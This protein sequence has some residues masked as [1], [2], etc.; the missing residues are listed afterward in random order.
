MPVLTRR[1]LFVSFLLVVLGGCSKT[2]PTTSKNAT[3]KNTGL[4]EQAAQGSKPDST[5]AGRNSADPA[6]NGD[7]KPVTE[8]TTSRP[9]WPGRM[10]EF[11]ARSRDRIPVFPVAL[12]GYRSEPNKDFKGKPYLTRGSIHV[13]DGSEW[14]GLR[15]FPKA[16]DGCSSGLFMLRW[17]LSDPAI[18]VYSTIDNPRKSTANVA[19][20]AFGYMYGSVCDKPQFKFAKAT[21]PN[22][23]N[24]VDVFYEL[25]FWEATP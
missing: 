4:R 9:T 24:H 25:K 18:R 7:P 19:T 10:G 1:L 8:V 14:K 6:P 20:G 3:V 23:S 5:D 21:K 22:W 13:E 15:H 16:K 2:P 17:R 11:S 12:S